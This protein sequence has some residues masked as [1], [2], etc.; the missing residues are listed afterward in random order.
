ME[1]FTRLQWH[2]RQNSF[3]SNSSPYLSKNKLFE[4]IPIFPDVLEHIRKYNLSSRKRTTSVTRAQPE[5]INSPKVASIAL[6]LFSCRF[7][8]RFSASAV[9][10]F[11][12][13]TLP[14]VAILGRSNFSLSFFYHRKELEERSRGVPLC[15]QL[16]FIQVKVTLESQVC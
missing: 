2:K 13:E 9:S 5:E 16:T 3:Q 12:V 14:E 10:S 6:Q 11:P 15:S 7:Q 8:F 4:R 1:S